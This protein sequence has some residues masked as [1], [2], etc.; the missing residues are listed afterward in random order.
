MV[1]T[2]HELGRNVQPVLSAL[3]KQD[4]QLVHLSEQLAQQMAVLVAVK[5]QQQQHQAMLEQQQKAC[6]VVQ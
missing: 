3:K 5:Q 6:C 1:G 4:E 2:A